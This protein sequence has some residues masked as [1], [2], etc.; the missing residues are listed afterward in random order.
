[1]RKSIVIAALVVAL[2]L[3]SGVYGK[4]KNNTGNKAEQYKD[5]YQLYKSGEYKKALEL[6]EKKIKAGGKSMR[7]VQLKFNLLTRFKRFK[8]ALTLVEQQ[9]KIHGETDELLGA[10]SN[11]LN[12]MGKTSDAIRVA[13]KKYNQSKNQSPWDCMNIMHLYLQVNDVNEA[14]NWLQEAVNQGFINYRI[15]ESPRYKILEEHKRF[16]DIIKTIKFS[17]G[18]GGKAKNFS[19][20]LLSG[21]NFS[22]TENRGK[23]ILV[24]FWA[25]WCAPC[26]A[27]TRF[28]RDY[29]SQFKDKGFE[30][31]GISLDSNIDMAKKFIGQK[32][33]DWK[34]ACTGNVWNDK[35][36]KI[37]GV[38]NLPTYFLIDRRGVLRSIDLKGEELKKAIQNLLE[39][40]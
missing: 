4:D 28:L 11:A 33:L 3:V 17:I 15:L 10:K 8:E 16:F 13:V 35:T 34:Q 20:P 6:V 2:S 1:M 18:L 30:I 32:K 24:Q 9:I 12:Y 40:K 7:L 5:I 37:Y 21:G 14:L 36:V 22:L 23:V 39:G 27:E 25:T 19:T 29:Y 31:V 26:M 38:N